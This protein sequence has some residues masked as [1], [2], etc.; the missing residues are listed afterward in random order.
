MNTY[1]RLKKYNVS[2]ENILCSYIGM[3][4]SIK[5][6]ILYK[7]ISRFNTIPIKI[8]MFLMGK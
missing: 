1:G 2:L 7:M 3:P 4:D 8:I 6:A 5:M